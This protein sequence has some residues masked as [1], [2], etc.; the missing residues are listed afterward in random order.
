MQSAGAEVIVNAAAQ[1]NSYAGAFAYESQAPRKVFMGESPCVPM[2][3]VAQALEKTAAAGHGGG[4]ALSSQEV[5][6]L[7]KVIGMDV[8]GC[9]AQCTLPMWECMSQ[10]P[11]KTLSEKMQD[12]SAQVCNQRARACYQSCLS[13]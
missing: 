9:A 8:A 10:V 1:D 3:T 12:K 2:P 5:E 11:G 6:A 4:G 13:G 7:R